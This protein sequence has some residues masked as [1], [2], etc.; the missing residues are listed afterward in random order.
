MTMQVQEWTVQ[1]AAWP[2]AR[3]V[4]S[5]LV[6]FLNDDPRRLIRALD[7]EGAGLDG[8]VEL[9]LLDDGSGDDE[10]AHAVIAEVEALGMPARHVRLLANEGRSKGR[11]RLARHSRGRSLLFLD[12]D[13]LPDSPDF[14]GRYLELIAAEDPA[15]AFGGFSLAQADVRPEHRLH[16]KLALRSDC[17][18]ARIRR[19]AP[20]KFVFTSNLLIRRDI[21]ETEPFDEAFTGWGWE[22]VEWG[23]RISRRHAIMH[24]DNPATHLGLDAARILAAKYE[25]SAG[26]FGLILE[27]HPDVVRRFPT[28][29]L[30]RLMKLLPL[31]RGWR[32]LLKALALTEAA[33]IGVRALSL[34]LYRVAVT[35]DAI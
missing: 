9:V 5:V 21:F 32:A 14:L 10:L 4:L 12:A 30:G 25:Q 28:Y 2:E 35:A 11:N 8:Q 13:M 15:A 23:V 1:N 16:R 26:N 7:A 18:P 24:I 3:P 17:A 34:R 19:R 20:A 27:A 22:D 33:P 29:R 6:P 31:R